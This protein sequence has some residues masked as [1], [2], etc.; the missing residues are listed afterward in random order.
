[1]PA[2]I[3]ARPS[4]YRAALAAPFALQA[5][6]DFLQRRD[7][8]AVALEYLRPAQDAFSVDNSAEPHYLAVVPL[9]L[10]PAVAA[11]RGAVHPALEVHVGQVEK[12]DVLRTH[13]TC[14]LGPQRPELQAD[15]RLFSLI[16]QP[17]GLL[18][19][20]V[21]ALLRLASLVNPFPVETQRCIV[22]AGSVTHPAPAVAYQLRQKLRQLPPIGL[23]GEV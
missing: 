6:D 7:I 12:Q 3:A 21:L 5:A 1:M 23:G 9:L 18:C 20:L 22:Q 15:H 13:A 2:F 4:S 17:A 19:Q 10:A 14:R 16:C 11:N 8:L